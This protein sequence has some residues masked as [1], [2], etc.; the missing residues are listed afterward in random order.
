MTSAEE[1]NAEQRNAVPGQSPEQIDSAVLDDEFA[2]A[3][4]MLAKGRL[5]FRPPFD[6]A[7]AEA[8]ARNEHAG[9]VAIGMFAATRGRHRPR[10]R[11][12]I[13]EIAADGVGLPNREVIDTECGA[14]PMKALLSAFLMELEAR[15]DHR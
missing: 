12:R 4:A 1:T 13:E 9:Q 11:V 14:G 15:K 5:L 8:L 2:Q 10:F 7:T 3:V 6:L